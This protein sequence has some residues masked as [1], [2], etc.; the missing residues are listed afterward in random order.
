MTENWIWHEALIIAVWVAIATAVD[1]VMGVVAVWVQVVVA[2]HIGVPRHAGD[3]A[4]EAG[5]VICVRTAAASAGLLLTA[6]ITLS[7]VFA[8][9][10]V[11]AVA[12]VSIICY[13][14]T[15]GRASFE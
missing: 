9:A 13:D 7:P 8:A 2:F 6:A 1:P 11:A 12:L 15:A 3:T 4:L 5:D 10:G 14:L